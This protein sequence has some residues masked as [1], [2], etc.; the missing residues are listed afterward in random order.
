MALTPTGSRIGG[1]GAN[2]ASG[3]V[4]PRQAQMEDPRQG[5]QRRPSLLRT[6]IDETEIGRQLARLAQLLSR[7]EIDQDAPRGSYLN[8]LV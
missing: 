3:R 6:A 1:Q 4:Q 7:D 5:P 8:F 2:G